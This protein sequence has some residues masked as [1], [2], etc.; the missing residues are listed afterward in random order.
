MLDQ[1]IASFRDGL[2]TADVGTAR[3]IASLLA[4]VASSLYIYAVYRIVCRRS[5]S[6][7]PEFNKSC[8]LMAVVTCGVIL[9]MQSSLIISLGMVGALSIIRFRNAVKSPT[10]MLFL[11]WSFASGIV[12]GTGLYHIALFMALLLTAGILLLDFVPV[13]AAPMLLIVSA[14]NQEINSA[15]VPVLK[16]YAKG[17]RVRSRTVTPERVEMIVELRVKDESGL[18]RAVAAIPGV[19]GVTLMT[20]SGELRV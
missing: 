12:C 7:S 18:V 20:H 10:D 17:A 6:Y 2:S 11:F 14:E 3:I 8:A 19:T 1:I 13:L 15:M 4:S 9:A 5:G 16:R